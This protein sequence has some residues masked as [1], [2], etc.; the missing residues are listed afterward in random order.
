MKLETFDRLPFTR[1]QRAWVQYAVDGVAPNT[2]VAYTARVLAN[3][4]DRAC[5]A[6]RNHDLR[7]A[8]IHSQTLAFHA[9]F[10][11]RKLLFKTFNTVRH[12]DQVVRVQQFPRQ[13]CSELSGEG[14][15]HKKSKGLRTEP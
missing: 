10:P 2:F 4:V 12:E 9:F 15:H 5:I 1:L 7:F 14:F 13:A 3:L 6:G 11:V 8:N